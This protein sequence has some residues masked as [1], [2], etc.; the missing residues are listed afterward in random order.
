MTDQKSKN[1][2]DDNLITLDLAGTEEDDEAEAVNPDQKYK[3]INAEE[4]LA[5]SGD[6]LFGWFLIPRLKSRIRISALTEEENEAIMKASRKPEKGGIRKIDA[7]MS[8]LLVVAYS[9]NKAN[10]KIGQGGQFLPGAL[11]YNAIK[12]ALSGEVTMCYK[13]ISR[14]SGFEES[15]E[16]LEQARGFFD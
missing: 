8:K 10:D 12:K 16:D 11:P 1:P 13:A 15:K 5:P 9:I 6:D 2:P 4:W 3:E 7:E 14:L